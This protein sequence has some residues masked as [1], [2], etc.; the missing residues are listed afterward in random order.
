MSEESSVDNRGLHCTATGTCLT[1]N[2]DNSLV[3]RSST[4]AYLVGFA[5]DIEESGWTRESHEDERRL[6]LV[7]G[8]PSR[9]DCK[10]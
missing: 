4:I 1:E 9:I 2:A 3:L 5:I 7:A 6:G 10:A 8:T